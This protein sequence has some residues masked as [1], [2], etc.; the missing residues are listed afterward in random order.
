MQGTPTPDGTPTWT[1]H[2]PV[3]NKYYQI[4]WVAHQLLSRWNCGSSDRL[5]NALNSE[6]T[7]QVSKEDV[8]DLVKFLYAN[9]LTR[10]PATGTSRAFVEQVE[11]QRQHWVKWLIHHYLFIRIPLVRPDRFLRAT[12]PI[13]APLYTKTM[14]WLVILLGVIGLYLV[15]QQWETF[16]NT[17]LYF[18][19]W[20][21]VLVYG[22]AF[23]LVKI[24]HEL[25][26]AYTATRYGCDWPGCRV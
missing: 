11:G 17:F 9:S 22:L 3:R 21:G 6:T 8:E 14:G 25:G 18:F 19:T 7:H 1:I 15:G 24:L 26:H 12:L 4:G 10:D 20:E 16:T 2:D 5:V 23:G 13:V